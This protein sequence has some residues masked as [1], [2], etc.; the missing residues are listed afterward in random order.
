MSIL[1]YT[2]SVLA[3][4]PSSAQ[5]S[6]A[7]PTPSQHPPHDN[8]NIV[9]TELTP[10]YPQTLGVISTSARTSFTRVDNAADDIEAQVTQPSGM[11]SQDRD[12]RSTSEASLSENASPQSSLSLQEPPRQISP[13]ARTIEP[14]VSVPLASMT[15]PVDES[16]SH[17]AS[18]Q[19]QD[20]P[21]TPQA[22]VTF[23]LVSGKRRTM[24][25]EPETTIGRVKELI[26]N[27]WP[28]GMCSLHF[29]GFHSSALS[30]SG[31]KTARLHPHT[32]A[33]YI[34]V[35]CCRTMRV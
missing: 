27:A 13:S 29:L 18:L 24:S 14:D 32:C 26:W 8:G 30:Q 10:P 9:I 2:P 3:T 19:R 6:A 15:T 1:S 25:F 21:Q 28:S 11:V 31:K 5:G 12:H 20:V 33:L 34:W 7:T 23:L 16:T 4:V 35:R 22:F 17:K